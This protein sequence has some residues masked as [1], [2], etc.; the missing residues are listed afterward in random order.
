M[1][2]DENG[3]VDAQ[4][5]AMGDCVGVLFYGRHGA[6]GRLAVAPDQGDDTVRRR[7]CCRRRAAGGVR[8]ARGRTRPVHRGREPAGRRRHARHRHGGEGRSG[9][10][11][12]SCPILGAGD[13]AGDL[14]QADL[15]RH[16]GSRLGAD[17]RLQRQCDDRAGHAAVENRAGFHRR[18]QGEARLDFVRL[19]RRRQRGAYQRREIPPCRRDRNNPRALPRRRRSDRR[20]SRRPDRLL[21]LPARHRAASDQGRPGAGA[22][23]LDPAARRR[24]A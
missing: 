13:R 3:A 10:L 8:R 23:G 7:K 24:S 14:S 18:R 22:G 1:A 19:G 11:Q 15:R 21:F 6:R 12:H 9:R 2:A 5:D 20:H 16:Q 4:I 17:D